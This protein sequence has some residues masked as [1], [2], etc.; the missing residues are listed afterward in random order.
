MTTQGRT[1]DR[2]IR[3]LSALSPPTHQKQPA[4][5]GVGFCFP[6]SVLRRVGLLCPLLFQCKSFSFL[7]YVHKRLL[8]HSLA[9][10]GAAG[11][12]H[13]PVPRGIPKLIAA[14]G[15]FQERLEA[16]KT[17][18]SQASLTSFITTSRADHGRSPHAR[19]PST[20]TPRHHQDNG[21]GGD[22]VPQRA[23]PATRCRPPAQ[24]LS[25]S[26][27]ASRVGTAPCCRGSCTKATGSP[28]QPALGKQLQLTDTF[29]IS[30]TS[31][32]PS[33]YLSSS[34]NILQ[35]PK[36]QADKSR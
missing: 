17:R 30:R 3:D 4:E 25:P 34:V 12:Y 11:C 10:H 16:L 7:V 24:L 27:G 13:A 21:G 1:Q 33:Q 6:V 32:L 18:W 20:S 9:R 5:N 22:P 23:P 35:E 19:A 31:H 8:L 36:C 28:P 15:A 2:N 14:P 26:L 29:P